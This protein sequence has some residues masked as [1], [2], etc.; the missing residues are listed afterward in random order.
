[1]IGDIKVKCGNNE[2]GC[3][4]TGDLR[5]LGAHE[6]KCQHKIVQELCPQPTVKEVDVNSV[7]L[8][9][10][11]ERMSKY[12]DGLMEKEKDIAYLKFDLKEVKKTLDEKIFEVDILK[13]ENMNMKHEL[14]GTT[15]KISEL[16]QIEIK[17]E[18]MSLKNVILEQKIDGLGKD[19][20][21]SNKQLELNQKELEMVKGSVKDTTENQV[22]SSIKGEV[23]ELKGLYGKSK[24]YSNEQMKE[25]KSDIDADVKKLNDTLDKALS[26]QSAEISKLSAQVITMEKQKSNQVDDISDQTGLPGSETDLEILQ[27]HVRTSK[28]FYF[29]IYMGVLKK[30]YCNG[31]CKIINIISTLGRW[32]L[33]QY[34]LQ[35]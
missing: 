5:N 2:T 23:E 31:R 32:Y 22:I 14:N 16:K 24:D 11:C 28:T 29:V 8:K 10:L 6:G 34:S 1:V 27:D 17:M 26:E 20:L 3:S 25:L 12:E 33:V 4:W 30:Y 7:M 15:N 19:L 18:N 21:F 35:K 9:E 13:K